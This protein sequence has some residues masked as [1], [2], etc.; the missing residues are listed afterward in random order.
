MSVFGLEA[1]AQN[2]ENAKAY[3]RW[4]ARNRQNVLT[5][6]FLNTVDQATWAPHMAQLVDYAHLFGVK[7]GVVVGFVDQQQN[8]YG[9]HQERMGV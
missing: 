8:A 1:G 5:F 6:H 3:I 7:V 9:T 2:L 4:L